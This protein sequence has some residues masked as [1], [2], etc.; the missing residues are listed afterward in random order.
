MRVSVLRRFSC[1]F[2]VPQPIRGQKCDYC[3]PVCSINCIHVSKFNSCD[4]ELSD[5]EW[6]PGKVAREVLV[7]EHVSQTEFLDKTSNDLRF[8]YLPVKPSFC[9]FT[10]TTDVC[11]GSSTNSDAI[12][13]ERPSSLLQTSSGDGC[14]VGGMD[15][16]CT[17]LALVVMT[18]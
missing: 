15:H 2:P 6:T 18:S 3:F 7:I 4:D 14:S 13:V 1:S 5:T 11:S 9:S 16:S 8:D 12:M 17:A 10:D